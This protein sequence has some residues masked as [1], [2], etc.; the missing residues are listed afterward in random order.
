MNK[1][2]ICIGVPRTATSFLHQLYR[3]CSNYSYTYIKESNFFIHNKNTKKRKVDNYLK[4]FNRRSDN[5]FECSPAY[6]SSYIAL[7]GIKDC[8]VEPEIIFCTRNVKDRFISQYNHHIEKIS[9]NFPTFEAYCESAFNESKDWFHPNY[10]LRCSEYLKTYLTLLKIFPKKNIH[11]LSFEE[12]E[13]NPE[14]WIKKIEKI[15]E[16]KFDNWERK[17]KTNQAKKVHEEYIL[18]N[19]LNRRLENLEKNFLNFIFEKSKNL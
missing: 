4:L 5:Y 8:L 2:V 6:F 13:Y 11:H 15:S 9:P 19:K 16:C 17:K 7:N 10:N 3:D 1:F 18:P 14:N 12:L